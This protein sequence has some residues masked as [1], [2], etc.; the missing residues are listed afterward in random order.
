M[1]E[2]RLL[3]FYDNEQVVFFRLFNPAPKLL[4]VL[5]RY[6]GIVSR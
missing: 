3:Y 1:K 5:Y 4:P 2:E 6:T